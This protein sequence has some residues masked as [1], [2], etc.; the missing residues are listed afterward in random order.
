MAKYKTLYDAFQSTFT[1]FP[2]RLAVRYRLSGEDFHTK[3]YSE[4]HEVVKAFG[5]GLIHL[6]V[7]PKAHIAL[8]ADVSHYWLISDLAIQFIAGVDVPRGTDS[9]GDE[10]AYI[11]DHS[12]CEIVLVH[13]AA[14]I[15]KIEKGLSKYKQ[16]V[17]T[18]IVL[19][20][21]KSSAHSN[22]FTMTEIIEKG[23]QLI[24][25]NASE[26]AEFDKR[27][28]AIESDDLATIVYTSG[29]TGEPK[30]VMLSHSNFAH[31]LNV[32]PKLVDVGPDDRGLTLLPPWHIFGRIAEYLF[33]AS[34]TSITY[35]DIK[36][37]GE[38]MRK[39]QP[40]YVPAVPRI[41][42]GVYNKIIGV[43]KKSGKEGI[44]NF[45]KK[46]SLAFRHNK[47]LMSGKLRVFTPRNPLVA[48]FSS[49]KG[50]LFVILLFLPKKLGDILV[51]K[52]VLAATGGKMKGSISGGGALPGYI[53]DFFAAIGIKILEG[54]GLTETCPV[55]SVRLPGRVI[56]GTV[57]P[58]V[59]QT[60]AKLID[61]EGKDVTDVRGAKGTLH[62][63]G[64]QVMKGYYKNQK[65][66][67]EVL[68]N[69]GWF[70][71]G[72]LVMF[73]NSGEVSIVGRSKDTIVLVGGENVEP[74]PIE[75]KIK[76]SAFVDHVMCVG[77]DQKTIGA[78][79]VPNQEELKT[80]VGSNG[81][82]GDSLADWIKDPKV[83]D[84]FKKEISRLVS[85]DTGFKSFERV[86]VFRLL[87]KPF[88]QGDELNNT[89]KIKRH[90][91]TDK[92]DSL[93]KSMYA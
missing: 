22:V 5:V 49:I 1:L 50:L 80:W 40:T 14:Q 3:T 11:V 20:D 13:N 15:E 91:V 12:G 37:I 76:E 71:T 86:T 24:T 38:D 85:A 58:L 19:N 31:Q 9:T 52:K 60:E 41:W 87:E 42:E 57:G 17:K 28:P 89:L 23:R 35:T 66:T 6:G 59:E 73:T 69:D 68:T 56:P 83:N 7:K 16:Q 75:E 33:F 88:E 18:Y 32:L 72:D 25:S 77:Q 29:T 61:L 39:I 82:P 30:G 54:Y 51:F 55:L 64:P 63:R 74:T 4:L 2:D 79:I 21:Q 8:I 45:F 62:V 36:H 10:I 78:L 27:G 90:V 53:D 44:F 46:I 47:N 81:I 93:I 26:S 34:G 92:Y 43:V 48:F 67:D 65:K 70:N 84:L